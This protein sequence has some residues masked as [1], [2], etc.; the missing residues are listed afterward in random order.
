MSY[1]LRLERLIDAT[2]E[3]V[4]DAFTDPNAQKEWYQD[5]DGW[6]VDAGGDLRA[7]GRWEVAFGPPGQAPYREANRFSEVARP[8]RLAYESRFH[9]PDGR[10]FDTTLVITFEA[11]QGKTLLTI[12]QS[13]FATEQDRNDHQ[14]GWPGFIDRLERVV[15]ARKGARSASARS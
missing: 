13:G 14:G 12:R 4:F 7:G 1:E 6:K 5:Q 3:E 10:T 11:K 8:H 2:P 9:L 15:A